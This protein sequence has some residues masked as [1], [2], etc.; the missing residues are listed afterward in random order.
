M[1]LHC[2]APVAPGEHADRATFDSYGFD[3]VEA[4]V[5]AGVMEEEFG[6]PVDPIQLFENPTIAD[7]AAQYGRQQTPSAVTR[8]GCAVS[9]T[10][11]LDR[12]R[13]L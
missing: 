1:V 5:M 4:V 10:R 8:P 9:I 13:Q 6:V 11:G 2:G 7:F 3:S 12:R